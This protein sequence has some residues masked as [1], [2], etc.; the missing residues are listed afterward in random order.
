MLDP[1]ADV[2][3]EGVESTVVAASQFLGVE[4]R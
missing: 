4:T 2:D 3:L 1:G